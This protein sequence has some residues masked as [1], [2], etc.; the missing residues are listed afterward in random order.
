MASPPQALLHARMLFA[1]ALVIF[2]NWNGLYAIMKKDLLIT[3]HNDMIM[4]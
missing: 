4:T 3:N 2:P 1:L